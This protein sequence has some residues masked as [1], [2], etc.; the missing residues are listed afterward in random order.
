MPHK[1][2]FFIIG[3]PKCGTTSLW[4]WLVSHPNIFLPLEKE[5]HYFNTDDARRG[6]LTSLEQFEALFRDVRDEHIAICEAS[7]WY[8]SSRTAVRNILQY[9]PNARLI[10][11]GAESD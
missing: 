3:A 4:T 9:Q 1:P 2:N 11:D 6:V 5:P 8:L 10:V 7:V